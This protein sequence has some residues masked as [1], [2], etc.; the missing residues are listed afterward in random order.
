MLAL[1]FAQGAEGALWIYGGVDSGVNYY[2]GSG[3][4]PINW[5]GST[6]DGYFEISL[7]PGGSEEF[8]VT[9]AAHQ[10]NHSNVHL[11]IGFSDDFATFNSHISIQ[12]D[13]GDGSGWQTIGSFDGPG[14]GP[15]HAPWSPPPGLYFIDIDT[16]RDLV[17]ENWGDFDPEPISYTPAM[18]EAEKATHDPDS[19][20]DVMFKLTNTGSSGPAVLMMHFDARADATGGGQ[21]FYWGP[22]SHDLTGIINIVPMYVLGSLGAA[23]CPALILTVRRNKK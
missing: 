11:F 3:P 23:F 6:D 19:Y 7:G 18:L 8:Y 14:L 17:G 4:D 1:A 20:V 15:G 22:G 12:Y 9:I 2:D 13:I 5:R 10:K 21:E 16:E